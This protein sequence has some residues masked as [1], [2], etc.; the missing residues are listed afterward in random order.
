MF[1]KKKN[2]AEPIK[3]NDKYESIKKF[4]W[5]KCDFCGKLVFYKDYKKNLRVCPK[6]GHIFGMT[7]PQRFKMMFDGL[8]F[9][10]VPMPVVVDD[11]LG[12]TDIKP[13]KDRLSEAR[14]ETGMKDGLA[15]A[16]GEVGGIP[17][18]IAVMNMDF[19][20]GSMGRAVGEGIIAA[21]EHAIKH[22]QPFVLITSSGGARMQENLLSLMQMARTTAAINKL[23]DAR[24]PYIVVLADP[25]YGGVTASFAM[26]G[27]IHIAESGARIGFAGRRVIEQNL[28]EKLPANF[29][30]AEF[31]L[32]HGM[33]DIVVKRDALKDTLGNILRILMKQQGDKESAHIATPNH[34]G[35]ESKASDLPPAYQKVLLA[36][37]ENRPH[38]LDY[39]NGMVSGFIP[40]AGDRQ[41]GEDLA[42]IGGVG[43]FGGR[44]VVI[45][46]QEKGRDAATRT[47]HRF[48]MPTPEG[49]R[50]AARLM[51]LAEKFGLPIVSLV[52][53]AGAFA[54]KDAEERGQSQAIANSIQVGLSV[55]TPYIAAIVG[56]GGSGGAIAIATGD[57]VLMMENAVYSVIAPESCA[58]ICWKDNKFKAEAAEALKLTSADAKSL[59]IV[60]KVV[61]EPEG[62]AHTDWQTTMENLSK[63]IGAELDAL[64]KEKPDDLPAKRS[65]KFLKMTK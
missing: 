49:Y 33:V 42:L 26:I 7:P 1:W 28:H 11:P 37:N 12:F 52:D 25:T 40:L 18:T 55:K 4:M 13:Y 16:T 57:R 64:A 44:P 23:R 59:G 54:G 50:K 32:D 8:D 62:G 14:D 56:E 41:F 65:E 45:M 46:G 61:A 17:T 22:K 63:A 5:I 38:F 6:C 58:S 47:K 43:Y 19:I 53:T 51:M 60:D 27:D 34:G 35:M 15:A 20:G 10:A 29:Q 21:A 3:K 30:T 24:L 9:T 48:G 2:D 31:L 36:R 39:I